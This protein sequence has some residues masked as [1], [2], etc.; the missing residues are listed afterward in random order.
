LSDTVRRRSRVKII[1]YILLYRYTPLYTICLTQP[2]AYTYRRH[3]NVECTYTLEERT[4]TPVY[5][6]HHCQRLYTY[7]VFDSNRR[8]QNDDDIIS[9]KIYQYIVATPDWNL[10]M[11]TGCETKTENFNG[12]A[13]QSPHECTSYSAERFATGITC[14]PLRLA[15]IAFEMSFSKIDYFYTMT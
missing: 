14:R 13:R 12:G 9:S 3:I 8:S 15:T 2:R 6:H 1:I 5:R 7:D 4:P 10:Y 11:A